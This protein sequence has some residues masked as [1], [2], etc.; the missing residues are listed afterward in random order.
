MRNTKA[1]T[2]K[3]SLVRAKITNK[4]TKESKSAYCKGKNYQVYQYIAETCEFEA[5]DGS[6]YDIHKGAINCN[7][8]F[9][10]SKF[11]CSSCS[12]QYV[13]SNKIF[14]IDLMTIRVHLVSKSGKHSKVN[15]ERF[16][17]HFKLPKHSGMHD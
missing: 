2:L 4:D 1:Q 10:D 16:H 6:N 7:T 3:D 8:Y 9:T 5:S 15:E 13:G 17:Q 12:K 14:T 11:C